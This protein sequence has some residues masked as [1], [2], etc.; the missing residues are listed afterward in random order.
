MPNPRNIECNIYF[1]QVNFKPNDLERKFSLF[2]CQKQHPFSRFMKWTYARI[3]YHLSHWGMLP[4]SW[5]SYFTQG[6]FFQKMRKLW[7]CLWLWGESWD[8]LSVKEMR[9]CLVALIKPI[10]L[11]TIPSVKNQ[12]KVDSFTSKYRLNFLNVWFS[13]SSWNPG[14][15]Y[16]ELSFSFFFFFLTEVPPF[17]LS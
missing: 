3:Q 5:K 14:L 15:R 1:E 16:R 10:N 4:S 12:E 8:M 11:F 13:L 2:C 9:V 17:L 6:T 7:T